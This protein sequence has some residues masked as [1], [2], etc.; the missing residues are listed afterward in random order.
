MPR[1]AERASI[2][3]IV[4]AA[5]KDFGDDKCGVR[6]AALSYYTVFALPPLLILLIML[7]GAIWSPETIQ[8]ALESQFAGLVGSE[9]ARAIHGMVTAS[10]N[11]KSGTLATVLGFVGL[12]FGATGAF[13]SLQD[14]LNAV[15]EVKPDPKR[16]GVKAFIGKR[17]LSLGMLMG[18][19]F[20]LVVSLAVSAVLSAL[21]GMFG[22]AIVMQA[23][24][25][26]VSMAML[27]VLF[28]AMFK[29][30]P[31]ATISWR[32]AFIGG[33]VTAV[34]F[35][36]G[37][38]AIGLY[39]GKKNPGTAF[40]A[41]SALAVILVWIYYASMLVLFGAEF[42]QHFAERRGKGIAPK[43]G[44]VRVVEKEQIVREGGRDQSRNQRGDSRGVTER[45]QARTRRTEHYA[46][47]REHQDHARPRG[48]EPPMRDD[49]SIGELLKRVS[50]DSSHLVQQEIK[51]AK[52]ELKE[53]AANAGKSAAKVGMAAVLALPGL[54]AV[55]AALV[56]GL[57]ILIHSYWGS[58]LIVGVVI[59]V[60]AGLMAKRGAAGFS[61]GLKPEETIDT[62]REDVDWAKEEST[63][64]K[65]RLSA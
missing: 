61:S 41:A 26:V 25:F 38:F 18:I 37:K 64:V 42:T 43:K 1:D 57:G 9:G 59:L 35:E 47:M 3:S 22:E 52:T 23:I 20:L 44:A 36:L 30:V 6:A 21:S 55:T 14:A 45:G 48:G 46:G 51:L 28:A 54:M 34:L 56:I 17:L 50:T 40:G 49:V 10:Q 53:A 65:Q 63:R 27:A 2:W 7:A 5:F 4:K 62:I 19:A 29:F 60:I 13:L 11:S 31:D 24:T 33:A 15:W 12:I 32:D 39:L 58:A 16:G 8:R